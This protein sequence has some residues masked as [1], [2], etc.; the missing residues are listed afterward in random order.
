MNNRHLPQLCLVPILA[1]L[2]LL[3]SNVHAQDHWRDHLPAKTLGF[4]V[5]P[6]LETAE[7]KLAGVLD[8]LSFNYTGLLAEIK[9]TAGLG[10]FEFSQRATVIGLAS[11]SEEAN[12]Y[13]PFALLPTGEF[14]ALV[15][16]MEGDVT[17]DLGVVPVMGTDLAL[18]PAGDWTAL[19]LLEHA[20]AVRPAGNGPKLQ[21][22]QETPVGAPGDLSVEITTLGY[23]HLQSR[24]GGIQAR[25]KRRALRSESWP[26]RLEYLD[27][28][29]LLNR[30][31][32]DHLHRQFDAAQFSL[33]V[34]EALDVNALLHLPLKST[35][36]EETESDEN[37]AEFGRYAAADSLLLPE[38]DVI[39]STAGDG[40]LLL[41]QVSKLRL[42]YDRGRPDEID[43]VAYVQVRF[44]EFAAASWAAYQYIER[45]EL[46]SFTVSEGQPVAANQAILLRLSD[47]QAFEGEFKKM[48]VA[49]NRLV[50]ESAAKMPVKFETR[51]LKREGQTGW[52]FD[53]NMAEAFGMQMTP[54][55]RT[56]LNGYYGNEGHLIW[57]MV[58]IGEDHCLVSDLPWKE[59]QLI[60][61]NLTDNNATREAKQSQPNRIQG[62]LYADRYLAWQEQQRKAMLGDTKVI[63]GKKKEAMPG[64]PPVRFDAAIEQGG[65]SLRFNADRE[66]LQAVGE[67]LRVNR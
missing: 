16:A 29:Y 13:F 1:S 21:S 40:G 2:L 6:D 8:D 43:A 22:Q 25:R 67:Y 9:S 59:T 45:F 52:E 66:T 35:V 18:V 11:D 5:A 23:Q 34:D 63:G 58:R 4:V 65:L 3:T 55:L 12:R 38:R 17:G 54:E 36:F 44:A 10:E 42:A 7:S 50:S 19:T 61:E 57:R 33:S 20:G 49:W 51:P 41:E 48:V 39:W 14:E 37:A 46:Q 26:P 56:M 47:R 60:V 28:A 24:A 62:M 53:V 64:A 30:P 32:L 15:H 31:L 27:A